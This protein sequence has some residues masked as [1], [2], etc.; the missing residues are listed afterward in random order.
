MSTPASTDARRPARPVMR[1]TSYDVASSLLMSIAGGMALIVLVLLLA[2]L[3]MRPRTATPI[4]PV[5]LVESP[6]GSEDGVVGETLQLDTP[7]EQTHDPSQA[8]TPSEANEVAE[9]LDSVLEVADTAV[10]QMP[11]QFEPSTRDAGKPG[12]SQGTGRRALGSGTGRAGFPREQRWYIRYSDNATIEEYGKQLDFFGVE[13]G[14]VLNE[15]I[16][17]IS[18]LGTAS[19]VVRHA[20][21]GGEEKRLYMTWQGGSRKTADIQLFQKAGVNVGNSVIFQFYP[22]NTENMLAHLELN[23]RNRKADEIRRTYFDVRPAKTG[24]EFWVSK[25]TYLK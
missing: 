4:V 22:A 24:Y 6:G 8:E 21:G 10:V 14:T 11:K 3:A 2:W 15:R 12:S 16:T 18:K 19:P 20:A 17:Y 9:S 23:Y 1:E 13:L 5:D 25:Q 7:A